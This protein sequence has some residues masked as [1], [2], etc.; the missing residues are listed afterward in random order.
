M[1]IYY[2]NH[3][4]SQVLSSLPWL[5]TPVPPELPVGSRH[6]AGR[7]GHAGPARAGRSC[8]CWGAVGHFLIPLEWEKHGGLTMKNWRNWWFND[9]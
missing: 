3:I 2:I 8:V 7:R 9:I 6:G 4:T 1:Y 5:R